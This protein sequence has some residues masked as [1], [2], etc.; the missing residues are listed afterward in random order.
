MRNSDSSE[1]PYLASLI[2]TNHRVGNISANTF[3][4]T[5][6]KMADD[7]II[8]EMTTDI[9]S[10]F[11]SNNAVSTSDLSSL[12]S[13]VYSALGTLGSE[14]SPVANEAIKVTPAQIRKSITSEALISFEDGKPYTTLKR[15]LTK[16]GLTVEEYKAKWNLPSDYPMTAP[17]Y[18][19]RRSEMAKSL[20]LGRKAGE[21]AAEKKPR[22]AKA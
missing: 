4:A 6:I 8:I 15:H 3:S 11:V 7:A 10:A 2:L 13:Q 21:K 16:H 22:K 12:I 20:G 5:V 17:A 9:V 18:S 14:P 19:A 1:L